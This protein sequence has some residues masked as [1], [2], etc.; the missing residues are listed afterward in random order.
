MS[1][2]IVKGTL[3]KCVN[4]PFKG[5]N[6]VMVDYK[7]ASILTEEGEFF[8]VVVKSPEIFTE[9]EKVVNKTGKIILDIT[10]YNGKPRE[11][12]LGIE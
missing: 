4:E 11:R 7:K 1:K 5:E 8:Q 12:F 3:L 9:Y 6:G 10:G 2:I